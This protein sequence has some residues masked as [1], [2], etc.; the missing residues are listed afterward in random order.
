[1]ITLPSVVYY[2]DARVLRLDKVDEMLTAEK[3]RVVCK[4]F[5]RCSPQLLTRIQ[6]ALPNSPAKPAIKQRCKAAWEAPPPK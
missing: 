3:Q 1:M 4:Q 2:K 5:A 6:A